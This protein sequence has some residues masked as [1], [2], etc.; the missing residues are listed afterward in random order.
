MLIMGITSL[1]IMLISI[2][3]AKYNVLY[4]S[5]WWKVRADI[6]NC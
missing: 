3:Y 1:H 6:Y 2:M 4:M 5:G